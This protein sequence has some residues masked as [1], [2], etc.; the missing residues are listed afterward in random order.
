MVI[1]QY[2]QQKNSKKKKKK[3]KKIKSKLGEITSGNPEHKSDDQLDAIQNV[4]NL[5]N[6]RQKVINWFT[7]N[8]KI[9]S[10]TI[11]KSKQNETTEAGLKIL[12][13][14]QMLQRLLIAFAQVNQ[15]IIQEV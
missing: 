13:T 10:E 8:A 4:Q 15:V 2:K 1:K 12:T 14:K 9:R 3:K 5:Y 6:S 7:D 11:Y